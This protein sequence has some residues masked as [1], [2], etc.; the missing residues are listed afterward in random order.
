MTKIEDV[1]V[2]ARQ[3]Y[4]VTQLDDIRR[5][6]AD[7]LDPILKELNQMALRKNE[8]V[9]PI[10][11]EERHTFVLLNHQRKQVSKIIDSLTN[12]YYTHLEK[13]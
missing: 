13:K 11:D 4:D 9:V 3:S 1:E 2:C 6:Q 10:T 5:F 7:N 8:G 12:A